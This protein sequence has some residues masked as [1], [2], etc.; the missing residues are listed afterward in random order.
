L[1]KPISAVV[2]FM[3][4]VIL[5][6]PALAQRVPPGTEAEMRE[7]LA[8]A[9]RVC[10]EGEQ[11]GPGVAAPETAAAAE[12]RSGQ[13]IYDRYC[14]ACHTTGA[15]GAPMLGDAAAWEPRV[16]RGMETLMTNTMQGIGAMPPMG[17][18]MDCSEA[19]L[20]ASVQ[21]ILDTL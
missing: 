1:S 8:P 13:E 12:Q 7:R 3:L 21:Y 16:A 18:C 11:C 4:A 6:M 14:F 2:C 17:T 5:A 20:E 9:G 15:A 19:E 10:L